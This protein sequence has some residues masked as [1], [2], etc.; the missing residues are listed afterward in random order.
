MGRLATTPDCDDESRWRDQPASEMKPENSNIRRS[1]NGAQSNAMMLLQLLWGDQ[2][3]EVWLDASP[4]KTI[5]FVQP[6]VQTRPAPT[7]W[8]TPP[9]R[10]FLKKNV[11]YCAIHMLL[12]L[13]TN[14]YTE[15][16]C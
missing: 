8:R 13:G 11:G 3:T 9:P 4:P 1:N 7:N 14:R 2:L 16:V 15:S 12:Q 10:S 6:K 5:T